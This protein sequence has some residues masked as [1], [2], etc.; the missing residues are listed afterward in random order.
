[1]LLDV[2]IRPQL[3]KQCGKECTIV[4][5]HSLNEILCL[6]MTQKECIATMNDLFVF[7]TMHEFS[8]SRKLFGV[9]D[10]DPN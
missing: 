4:F 1:M 2:N 7:K 9:Y 5:I 10:I 3:T 6:K 8:G